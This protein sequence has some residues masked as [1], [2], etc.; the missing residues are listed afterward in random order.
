MVEAPATGIPLE[1]SFVGNCPTNNNN[2]LQ[3]MCWL[4]ALMIYLFIRIRKKLG[5][6]IFKQY[7]G[8]HK[9]GDFPKGQT[10]I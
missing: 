9:S 10:E 6:F 2:N 1:Y 3:R 5:L 8:F 7:Q 4:S